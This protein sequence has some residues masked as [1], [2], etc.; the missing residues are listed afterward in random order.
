M[1]RT[2]TDRGL[3]DDLYLFVALRI[4]GRVRALHPLW[5]VT[6]VACLIALPWYKLGAFNDFTTKACIPSLIVLQV[7]LAMSIRGARTG[8]ARRSAAA[9][10]AL[11]LLGTFASL[12]DLSRGVRHGLRFSPPRL[13]GVSHVNELGARKQSAQLFSDGEAFFWRVLARP[14]SPR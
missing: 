6:A 2:G 4:D 7:F 13:E 8:A 5:W 11:L 9:L 10:V 14:T 12:A 1:R 3:A